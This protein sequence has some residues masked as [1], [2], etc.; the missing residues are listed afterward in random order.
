MEQETGSQVKTMLQKRKHNAGRKLAVL[1]CLTVCVTGCG[2]KLQQTQG[3]QEQLHTE[4]VSIV[5]EQ[6]QAVQ[7]QSDQAGEQ[8]K[9]TTENQTREQPQTEQTQTDETEAEPALIETKEPD[10]TPPEIVGAK[11]LSVEKGSSISYKKGVS[12]TDDSGEDIKLQVDTSGVDLNTA[13][14]YQ[15]RYYA[16]DSAGNS[17]EVTVKLTVTE[18]VPITEELVYALADEVIAGVVTEGMTQYQ[19]AEALWNWCRYK[20]KYTYSAGN[21][22]L[23]DGAYEGMHDRSGDCYVYYAT[24]SVL[25][26]RCGIEN[27]CV[28][29]TG[30]A[31]NHWWNLVNVG[32]GWYH[33]DTSP[34][35]KGDT[36]VCFM[37][38]DAQVAAYSDYYL[39]QHP[40]HPNYYGFDATLYPERAT[41]VLVENV[42]PEIQTETPTEPQTENQAEPQPEPQAEP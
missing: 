8:S 39:S 42:I 26:T 9:E 13:G 31:T 22:T 33:C 12:V 3:V 34:R 38:T 19:K 30:G 37:Q 15:V 29:R 2:G 23:L 16:Q 14:V 17:T 41:T 20:I 11:D 40:G 25:L 1:L 32:D 21:R 18:P 28:A 6:T 35:S 24:Y 36:F 27:I 4:E 5:Q 7:T 10:V